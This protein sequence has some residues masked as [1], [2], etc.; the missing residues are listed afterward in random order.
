MNENFRLFL[1]FLNQSIP[2]AVLFHMF[3]VTF[4]YPVQYLFAYQLNLSLCWVDQ[5]TCRVVA[6]V[7]LII[8]KCHK[9]VSLGCCVHTVS[10]S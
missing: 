6:E 5:P 8:L 7:W 9:G 10:Y 3:S 1:M 2:D 4:A